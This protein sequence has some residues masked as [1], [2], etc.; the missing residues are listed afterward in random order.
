M[1]TDPLVESLPYVPKAESRLSE[2]FVWSADSLRRRML[3]LADVATAL[4]FA[5]IY[6]RTQNLGLRPLLEMVALAPLW[7]LL[8]KLV[9]LY[10]KDHRSLRHVTAD[11]LPAL[12]LWASAGCVLVSLLIQ[13]DGSLVSVSILP[14][15]AAVFATAV[16]L[17]SLAR[18]VFRRVVPPMRVVIVGEGALATATR[19]KLEVF[20]DIHA[21]VTAELSI[22][23]AMTRLRSGVDLAAGKVDRLVIASESPPDPVIDELLVLCRSQGMTLSLLQPLRGH[24]GCVSSVTR[25]GELAALEY[26][27]FDVSRSTLLLKR[28]VDIVVASIGLILLLPLMAVA[29]AAIYVA[30][31]GPVFFRQR[32]AGVGGK[33]FTIWKFRTMA[34]DAEERLRELVRFD[35]LEHPVFKLHRDPRVTPVGRALRR[36][37]IDEVPQLVNVLH[38]EMSLVGPRPEQVELVERYTAEQRLRLNLKPG[39]TGPMQICGRG[40]LSLEERL[41]V[42]LDYIDN[43][44]L[45]RDLRILVHTLGPVLTGRGAS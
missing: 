28:A 38:G 19:R 45:G 24:F 7:V 40:E 10:D 5:A 42:E 8:A 30:D 16:C 33:S 37:S 17:R 12:L 36:F 41:A 44:S 31:R 39:L 26:N 4:V 43:L 21:V 3:A 27:T 34:V 9:G 35:E 11:E 6:A 29:A 2:P 15:I 13:E 14:V 18:A 1:T 22:T 20:R 25:V 32:R 23:A